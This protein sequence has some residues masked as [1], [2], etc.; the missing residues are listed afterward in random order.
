MMIVVLIDDTGAWTPSPSAAA[1]ALAVLAPSHELV[2]L[3]S[4]SCR[5]RAL[6]A[7]LRLALPRFTVTAVLAGSDDSEGRR[8]VAQLLEAGALPI[9]CADQPALLA[10]EIRSHLGAD[11]VLK[12]VTDATHNTSLR[13]PAPFARPVPT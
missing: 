2:V 9:V 3:C 10:A 13:R 1:A 12:L 4:G 6:A 8:T 7:A 5:P 11:L